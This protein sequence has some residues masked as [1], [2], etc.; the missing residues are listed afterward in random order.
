MSASR[1]TVSG[2]R[3]AS[4][5]IAPT[6]TSSRFSR[7]TAAAC[8][9]WATPI[10]LSLSPSITGN[11]E[12]PVLLVSAT[13]SATV[14]SRSTVNIRGRGVITSAAVSWLSARVL[15]S[16]VAVCASSAPIM[17][18][19]LTSDESSSAVLEELSSSFGSIPKRRT[20]QLPTPLRNTSKKPVIQVKAI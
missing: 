10:T 9:T 8:F 20:T 11:R 6:G 19:R 4:T 16:S 3:I 13:T 12:C 14:C 15:V 1:P 5:K 2:T 17:A 18:E 7:G